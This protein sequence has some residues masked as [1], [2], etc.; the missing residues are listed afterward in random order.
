MEITKINSGLPTTSKIETLNDQIISVDGRVAQAQFDKIELD[1]LYADTGLSRKYLRN[2]LLGNALNTYTGW[3]HIK[4]ENG[5]SIWKYT[6]ALYLYNANNA[7]YCDDK[8]FINM[9][10]ADALNPTA[11]NSVV[12]YDTSTYTY[13]TI[14]AGTELGTEFSVLPL[15]NH[16]LFVG[17]AT[18]FFGMK[19]E[20]QTRGSGYTLEYQYWN[21][22]D[23]TTL[24]ANTEA[25]VDKTSNFSGDG[26]VSFNSS[27]SASWATNTVDTITQYWIRIKTTTVPTTI[28]KIYYLVPN[29]S[30]I[31]LLSMNTED[32]FAEKWTWCTLGSDIYV[33]IRNSGNGLFEGDY[34]ITSSS[35]ATN[36]KNY[37]IY[38]HCISANFV[39]TSYLNPNR[40]VID[41]PYALTP[42]ANVAIDCSKAST[43]TLTPGQ[44]EA[45]TATNMVAGQEV[46]LII[47][48]SGT[49]SYTLTFSTG[50]KTATST[51]ATGTVSAK[52]F[53]IKYISNGTSLIELSRT[54]AL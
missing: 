2:Q 15:T 24:T 35:S 53:V 22:A 46:N 11:F 27:F 38:N 33:T 36:L 5:Y 16:Y 43:F 29:S 47:L 39:S 23:W 34:F 14:E 17:S 40:G 6:P 19:F 4:A 26:Y 25:L 30:V 51:L 52:Y 20:F 12:T 3:S 31:G 9:G 45:I 50:I 48:T 44:A 1:A 32:I 37:F 7:V 41:I 49:S 8:A 10:L 21:G 28:A 13:Y 18:R 42:S 54:T